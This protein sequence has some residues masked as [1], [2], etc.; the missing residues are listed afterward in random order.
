MEGESEGDGVRDKR[1]RVGKEVGR[2]SKDRGQ[3]RERE[4]EMVE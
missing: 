4:G 3:V 1:R 2:I